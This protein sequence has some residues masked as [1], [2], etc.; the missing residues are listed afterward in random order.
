MKDKKTNRCLLLASLLLCA[1]GSE[2]A[3]VPNAAQP[4]WDAPVPFALSSVYAEPGAPTRAGGSG[5]TEELDKNKAIGFYA[6]IPVSAPATRAGASGETY[7]EQGNVK[8]GFNEAERKW[9]PT[10]EEIWINNRTATIAVYAP[11]DADHPAEHLALSAALLNEGNDI[12]AGKVEASNVTIT[13]GNGVTATL[14][15]V[16]T[17]VQFNFVKDDAYPS[18]VSIS[19]LELAGDDIYATATYNPV[20]GTYAE[21]TPREDVSLTLDPP[22]AV[23]TANTVSGGTSAAATATLLLIPIRQ[24]FTSDA[25]LWVNTT[26]GKRMKVTVPKATFSAAQSR[27]FAPGKQYKLKVKLSPAQMEISGVEVIGWE[28]GATVSDDAQ[29]E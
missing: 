26:D 3:G 18:E 7:V 20:N 1:C 13:T 22:L 6:K 12:V 23:P 19:K 17:G 5:A 28:T 15:H 24:T 9:E 2:D 25:T 4:E 14:S 11:Y 16:Y 8:G 27:P 10:S 29:F 21:G